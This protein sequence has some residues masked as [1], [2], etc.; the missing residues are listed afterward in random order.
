MSYSFIPQ[1]KAKKWAAKKV[2]SKAEKLKTYYL[3]D[4]LIHFILTLPVS[5]TTT[6]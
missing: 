1:A 2:K 3:I 6:E 4:R 5:T